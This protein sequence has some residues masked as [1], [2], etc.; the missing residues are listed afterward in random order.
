M[1]GQGFITGSA[2]SG[3]REQRVFSV[4]LEAHL[5]LP[6]AHRRWALAAVLLLLS[7][8]L[9]ACL[10]TAKPNALVLEW[11]IL[12][13][14]TKATSTVANGG[15]ATINPGH[16]YY[17][18]L[19]VKDPDGIKALSIWGEGSFKCETDHTKNGGQYLDAPSPL[20]A[21]LPRQDTS[22][23]GSTTYAGFVQSAPFTYV[24]ISC[25]THTYPGLPGPQEY[26]VVSGTL[27]VRGRDTNQADV[28][29]DATLDL[30]PA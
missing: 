23:P 11:G 30:N 19:R 14:E 24:D 21:G 20:G 16:Q 1:Q 13:N 3:A 5:R 4:T 8:T 22:I 17:V 12:D 26:F 2:R 7:A 15:S 9:V 18:T 28:V 29:T 6:S 10:D 27:R 25:G